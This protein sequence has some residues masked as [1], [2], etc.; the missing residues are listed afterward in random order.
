MTSQKIAPTATT[1]IKMMIAPL[2]MMICSLVYLTCHAPLVQ[3]DG[4]TAQHAHLF[5]RKKSLVVLNSQTNEGGARPVRG[6][7][8]TEGT[9]KNV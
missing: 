7:I 3:S 2:L 8:L 1:V 4:P 9:E 5:K 6:A